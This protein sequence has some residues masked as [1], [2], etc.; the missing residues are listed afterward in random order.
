MARPITTEA[1]GSHTSGR[2]AE[3]RQ[4]LITAAIDTLKEHG[5]AGAS[6]RAIAERAGVNQAL[7][8][9][10]FDSVVGL[11][12]AAL[13]WVSD[14]RADRYGEAV[15]R[16]T[17][18]SDLVNVA[19]SIFKEDLEQGH[20]AVLL[21]MIAGASSTAGLGTEVA[22]RIEPWTR[23]ASGAI[24]GALAQSVLGQILPA[25]DIAFAVVALYLGL[26]MLAQL[27]G[28]RTAA[29]ALF[30]RAKALAPLLAGL[31]A[32]TTHVDDPEVVP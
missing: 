28:D 9:Y 27:G 2:G 24:G 17:S 25:G 6:A 8:F 16:A 12:L 18:P 11:L 29:T 7:V 13:D 23:F 31:G 3:T 26:E 4:R 1:A 14:A 10:H 19:R 22:R 21:A 30:E 5:F 32:A 20:A 15:A